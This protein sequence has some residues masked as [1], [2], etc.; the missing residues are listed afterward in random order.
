MKFEIALVLRRSATVGKDSCMALRTIFG[1]ATRMHHELKGLSS[2]HKV[3]P[4]AVI[5]TL[6]GE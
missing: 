3:S 6:D 1:R 2:K 5:L 4:H